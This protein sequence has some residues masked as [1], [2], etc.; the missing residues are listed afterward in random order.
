MV[1]WGWWGGDLA[2]GDGEVDFCPEL[3]GKESW[4]L[5]FNQGWNSGAGNPPNPNGLKA[6]YLW[7]QMLTKESL[8]NIIESFAQIVEEDDEQAGRRGRKKRKQ[9]F[10]RF[11]QLK[12][13]R[14]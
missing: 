5:P 6:D 2:G 8:A 3:K 7:K 14:A 13:V 1:G 9:V 10:P 4:F 12:T 11:H